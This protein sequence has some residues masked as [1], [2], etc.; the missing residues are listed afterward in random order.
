MNPKFVKHEWTLRRR[1]ADMINID[2]HIQTRLGFM[3]LELL[4][5]QQYRTNMFDIIRLNNRKPGDI[6]ETSQLISIYGSLTERIDDCMKAVQ[7]EDL[8]LE[9]RE[10]LLSALGHLFYNG[11]QG[12]SRTVLPYVQMH[13]SGCS[14][15]T[16]NM[17]LD[18][19][20]ALAQSNRKEKASAI[21]HFCNII[22]Q[23]YGYD[24]D[25]EFSIKE[26]KY[27]SEQSLAIQN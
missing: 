5:K 25:N 2:D 27:L 13:Q 24:V 26:L 15:Q 6:G 11:T 9:R 22:N 7:Y 20:T 4:S 19:Y 21:K 18:L 23:T 17:F 8:S 10:H 14:K 1:I 3:E 16:E 12:L